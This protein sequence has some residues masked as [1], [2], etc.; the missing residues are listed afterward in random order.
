[1]L[2]YLKTYQKLKDDRCWDRFRVAIPEGLLGKWAEVLIECRRNGFV[3][4]IANDRAIIWRQVQSSSGI[5][6]D[7]C[8]LC[9]RV[10]QRRDDLES[11]EMKFKRLKD[12]ENFVEPL[13]CWSAQA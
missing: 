11:G 2:E 10:C 8:T 6:H 1:M 9:E 3:G 5:Q 12:R 13:P 4:P 7:Q